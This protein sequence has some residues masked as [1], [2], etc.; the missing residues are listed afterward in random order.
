MESLRYN[1]RKHTANNMDASSATEMG[2]SSTN[3][4]KNA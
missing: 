2:V 4:V 1:H 3:T